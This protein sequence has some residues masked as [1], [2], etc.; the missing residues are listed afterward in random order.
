LV[1]F[2]RGHGHVVYANPERLWHGLQELA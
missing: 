1:G 2:V